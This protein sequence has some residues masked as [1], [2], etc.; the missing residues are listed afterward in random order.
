MILGLFLHF[1]GGN[2]SIFNPAFVKK[3]YKKGIFVAI[4]P[5]ICHLYQSTTSGKK[6]ECSIA[7]SDCNFRI[8]FTGVDCRRLKFGPWQ[9]FRF[10]YHT[11]H[12]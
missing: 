6:F 2:L 10:P 5:N 9:F 8:H 12:P 3:I 11:R 7:T 4:L 1:L